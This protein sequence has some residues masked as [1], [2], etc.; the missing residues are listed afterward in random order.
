MED[1][2]TLYTC[3]A[4][5]TRSVGTKGFLEFGGMTTCYVLKRGEYAIVIDCGTGLYFART[6]LEGCSK[7]DVLL[8]HLHFDHILGLLDWGIFPETS[9]VTFYSTFEV[10]GIDNLSNMFNLPFWPVTKEL[11][12]CINVAHGEILNLAEGVEAFFHP[13]H[14]PNDGNMIRVNMTH[15]N[16]CFAFDYEHNQQFPMEFGEGCHLIIY[17]GTYDDEEYEN[18]RNWGHSTW[19]E[20][21]KLGRALGVERTIITHHSPDS[22]D[23]VLL[24]REKAAHAKYGNVSFARAG[25]VLPLR[26]GEL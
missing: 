1:I 12:A 15:C 7:I 2:F 21:C 5:G 20:G 11:G 19:Q 3:G 8:T 17:D 16:V 24:A 9:A 25:D 23:D 10:W 6:I 14:H 26:S 18:Y 13:S 22:E 4:R